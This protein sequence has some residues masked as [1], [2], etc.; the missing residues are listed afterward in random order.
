LKGYHRLGPTLFTKLR[1]DV[2]QLTFSATA[3][4]LANHMED[5]RFQI[6]ATLHNTTSRSSTSIA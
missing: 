1:A 5:L 4:H 2:E 3:H 6:E